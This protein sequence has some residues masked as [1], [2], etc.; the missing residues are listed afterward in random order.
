M[1]ICRMPRRTLL[2][3]VVALLLGVGGLSAQE[4]RL[5]ADFVTLFDNT[6]YSGMRQQHSETLFSARLTPKV[7]LDWELRNEL[8]VAVDLNKDFGDNANMLS[9]KE[10]QFYYGYRTEQ[11]RMIA[12]IFP[13]AEMRGLSSDIFFDRYHR[14]HHNRLSGVLARKESATG[15]SFV[16]F[17]MDYNGKRTFVTREAF[18]IMTSARYAE[19]AVC[20]GYD[21]MMGHYAKDYNPATD[22]DVVDNFILAPYLGAAFKAGDMDVDCGVRYVQS[23]QRD[24]SRENIFK[25]PKG[26]EGYVAMKYKGFAVEN[27]TYLGDALFTYYGRY[28]NAS[29]HGLQHFAQSH[30]D[31]PYNALTLSY[32]EVFSQN[33]VFLDFGFT[34]ESDSK[35]MGTR[36]WLCVSVMLDNLGK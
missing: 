7:A 20:V 21:I 23:V 24:R 16:E 27:R 8:V 25:T 18:E 34:L 36:Q 35:G 31:H 1:F 13:R 5:G 26:V 33:T 22:D 29:Y 19:R 15:A 2:Y 6:E 28:G 4:L 32:R 9:S 11:V 14:F 12:G 10:I 17:A 30:A 3:L